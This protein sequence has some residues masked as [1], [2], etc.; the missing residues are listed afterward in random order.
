M[1]K[2][3]TILVLALIMAGVMVSACLAAPVSGNWYICNV[4]A[5]GNSGSNSLV[6]LT[7]NTAPATFTKRWFLLSGATAKPLLATS[8]TGTAASLR[9]YANLP[10]TAAGS[11]I[12]YFYVVSDNF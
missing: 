8:L 4:V 10:N 12:S 1:K 7:D 5:T 3:L 11:T 6:M 9:V 2:Q